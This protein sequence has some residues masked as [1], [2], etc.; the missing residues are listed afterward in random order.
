MHVGSEL[1]AAVTV[2]PGEPPIARQRATTP[3]GV[4]S[5]VEDRRF[6]VSL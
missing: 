2:T 4:A 6:V 1:D 3:C 5:N